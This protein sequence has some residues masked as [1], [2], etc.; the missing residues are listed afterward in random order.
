MF[1]A[2]NVRVVVL[3]RLNRV[4]NRS[5]PEGGGSV[6]RTIRTSWSSEHCSRSGF[7]LELEHLQNGL[8]SSEVLHRRTRGRASGEQRGS[9][10]T[11]LTQEQL[12]DRRFRTFETKLPPLHKQKQKPF[13]SDSSQCFRISDRHRFLKVRASP[14]RT[15]CARP[16]KRCRSKVSD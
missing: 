5:S 8:R 10:Q 6:R 14:S 2:L 13:S 12:W 11:T 4:L 1:Q 3:K 15:F 9:P 16:K 7:R